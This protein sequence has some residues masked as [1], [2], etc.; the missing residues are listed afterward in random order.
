M[1]IS[2]TSYSFH[3]Y[4][5]DG[6]Y[7]QEDCIRLAKE[8][9]FSAI[10]FT[11]IAGE[12]EDERIENAKSI[13][14]LADAAE[15]PIVAYAVGADLCKTTDAE[16]DAEIRRLCHHVDIAHILGAPVMRHDT[17]FNYGRRSFDMMLPY[18]VPIARAVTRYAVT[19]GIRT[20][21]EN[22]GY[23]SQDSD[24][25]ERFFNAVND[26]NFGVLVD[27]GNFLCVDENPL[28]AVSRL[29][30]YAFHCHAKD[31]KRSDTRDG[32]LVT[33]G[34]NYIYG[35]TLGTGVVPVKQ[36][37]AIMKRNGYD[38]YITL[39]YEG[40][41]DPMVGIAE[42]KRNLEKYISEVVG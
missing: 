24:R 39:E 8:L 35:A 25:V 34:A 5:R 40:R 19:L 17:F 36:C 23:I 12:N 29:A 27:F 21:T 26:D 28:T 7:R 16:R 15:L 20:C 38:G 10:E 11:D 18:G 13:R 30:P 6:K 1:K 14:A 42:G 3:K 22:H 37:L 2:V 33:R 32:C 4:I 9:G 41:D 31:F